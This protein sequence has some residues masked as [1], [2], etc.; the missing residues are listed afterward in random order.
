MRNDNQLSWKITSK[1]STPHKM[2]YYSITIRIQKPII[3]FVISMDSQK[4]N[5]K[6]N[7]W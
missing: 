2:N 3:K 6:V 4:N 7:E 1:L 5:W